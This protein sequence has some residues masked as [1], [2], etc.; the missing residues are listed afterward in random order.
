[1]KKLKSRKW[2]DCIWI[3]YLSSCQNMLVQPCKKRCSGWRK[4]SSSPGGSDWTSD[5]RSR[6]AI[7]REEARWTITDGSGSSRMACSSLWIHGS[8]LCSILC[9]MQQFLDI[10]W[11]F[12]NMTLESVGRT[13]KIKLNSIQ[14]HAK[15]SRKS[16]IKPWT[17]KLESTT[18]ETLDTILTASGHQFSRKQRNGS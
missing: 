12:K 4:W 7:K 2:C 9:F 17:N 18:R 3:V 11:M 16:L 5:L 14:F 1:M 6:L 8:I 15:P 10:I 13:D